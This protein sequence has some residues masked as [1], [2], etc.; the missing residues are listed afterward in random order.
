VARRLDADVMAVY[1]PPQ[2]LMPEQK[3]I[4]Y[5]DLD[6]AKQL[7]IKV[8]EAVG[9]T[10]PQ[11]LASYALKNQVTE[12]L[13]GHSKRSRLAQ[14]AFGSTVSSLIGLVPGIDVLVIAEEDEKK[15]RRA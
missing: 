13:I 5:A 4:F 14:V 12:I 2:K 8:E 3:K 7:N 15:Q 10:I 1:C 11:A 6:L 9:A